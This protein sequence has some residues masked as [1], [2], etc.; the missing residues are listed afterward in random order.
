MWFRPIPIDVWRYTPASGFVPETYTLYT[1]IE[2]TFM[3]L[4]GTKSIRN[5]QNFADVKKLVICDIDYE[6]DIQDSDEVE[7]E[8]R[9]YRVKTVETFK[10][11]LPHVAIYLGDSQWTRTV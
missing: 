4:N 8:D 1:T 3:P 7:I 9:W 11:I 6:N 2:G 5:N 10:N